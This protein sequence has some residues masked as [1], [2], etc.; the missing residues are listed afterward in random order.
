[1]KKK[2]DSKKKRA[3]WRL[4][5]TFKGNP[6]VD[7][8]RVRC[9]GEPRFVQLTKHL[10]DRTLSAFEYVA[11]CDCGLTHFYTYNV[12]HVKSRWHIIIRVFRTPDK[13]KC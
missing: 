7:G 12:V 8:L 5:K 2:H 6:E 9:D 10:N 4:P 1:M 3:W 11:C 13:K